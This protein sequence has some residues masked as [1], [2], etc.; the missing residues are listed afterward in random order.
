MVRRPDPAGTG[1]AV[2]PRPQLPAQDGGDDRR[3]DGHGPP[4]RPAAGAH[5]P[6]TAHRPPPEHANAGDLIA[7]HLAVL[8]ARFLRAVRDREAD[9]AGCATELRACGERI[10]SVVETYHPLLDA[11]WATLLVPELRWLCDELTYEYRHTARLARLT[12]ALARLTAVRGAA[13]DGPTAAGAARAGA[14]LERQLTQAR[15]RAR[16]AA[17]RAWGSARFHAVADAVALLASEAPLTAAS[18]GRATRVLPPL[19]ARACDQLAGAVA[20]LPLDVAVSP[21]NTQALHGTLSGPLPGDGP[22][23]PGDPRDAAWHRVRLLARGCRYALEVPGS[24]PPASPLPGAADLYGAGRALDRH[25]D[26]AEAAEAA[27]TAARTPRITP[28]TAYA[29]GVLHAD[30]RTEAEAARYAFGTLWRAAAAPVV[31]A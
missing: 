26:A 30:Q 10:A 27:A 9:E 23:R 15:S 29:L 22:E 19:A 18:A 16:T 6:V 24:A 13:G 25:R 1:R 28:A 11:E 17:L 7:G 3:T 21:Y 4:D 12:G 20:A 8:S 2:G 14:L 5:A 31:P